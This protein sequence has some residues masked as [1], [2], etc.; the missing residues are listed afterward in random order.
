ME[1]KL[2][3]VLVISSV[4]PFFGPGIVGLEHYNAIRK[5]GCEADFMTKYPVDGHPEFISIYD[6]KPHGFYAFMRKA[7]NKI[8]R[9]LK[10]G[11]LNHQNT[12]HSFFYEKETDPIVPV[13]YLLSKI[14][15]PYD[16]V[17]IMFWQGVLSFAHIDAIYDKLKCQIQF[18]CVDYSPMSGGCHFTKDCLRYQIGCGRCPGINSN[19][20]NDFTRFNVQYRKRVYEK[21]KP[22]VY[23][24]TYMNSFYKK[25]YLLK[26]YG[27]LEI[28][29][30][31][32]NN[33][34]YRPL[35]RDVFRKKY[36]IGKKKSFVILFGCQHLDDSRKGMSFLLRSLEFLYNSLYTEEREK[37]QLV[38]I[39]HDIELIKEKLWFDYIYLGYVKPT[40]L[41]GIYSMSS[42]FLSPSVN[43][44]G[45]SMV[46]QA[47]SC[48]TPIVS[49]EMGTALD[50]VKNRGTGYCAK[51]KDSEDFARGIL[52]I[53]HLADDEYENMRNLCRKTAIELT[54]DVAFFSNFMR[55]YNLY[56]KE[57][58]FLL[59]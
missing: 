22:I 44:A 11:P 24:N 36:H 31:L 14:T 25:S 32:S 4:D 40:D 35:D 33:E 41:P 26:D 19:K 5:G 15:R 8:T 21:V 47:M 13:D 2:P 53:L 34:T 55:V 57:N 58:S 52:F 12:G 1:N 7:K 49:F 43:D 56:K 28:V 45:P 46:N 10:I 48:G 39:G 54:S 3:R 42:V 51:L 17:Y 23:G 30:P 50:V 20:E 59:S 27:R 9:K 16:I 38:I 29:Y 6:S 18:R 37:I